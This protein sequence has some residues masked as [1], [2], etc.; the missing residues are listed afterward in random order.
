MRTD[1]RPSRVPVR[2]SLALAVTVGGLALLLGF[3]APPDAS[4][5]LVVAM[6]TG[7]DPNTPPGSPLPTAGTGASPLPT[8]GTGASLLPTAGTGASPLPAPS[9]TPGASHNA[10]RARPA[11]ASPSPTQTPEPTP[12]TR[13]ATGKAYRHPFGVVQV[14]VTVEGGQ[15]VD[16]QALR[17]PDGDRHSAWISQQV[18]PMLRQSALAVDSANID[19]VS[20]ATYTSTAYAYSLQSALDQLAG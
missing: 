3:R 9:A 1:D 13:T 8:A 20:G 4:T 5:E 15:I 16:V 10:S 17:M 7:A 14:A 2:G 6:D 19:I 11:A 18:E 12:G